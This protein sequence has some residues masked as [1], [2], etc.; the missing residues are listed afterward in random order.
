MMSS[1]QYSDIENVDAYIEA[2]QKG[3]F[4]IARLT[5][6]TPQETNAPSYHDAIR[7]CANKPRELSEQN[8]AYSLK[9]HT[10]KPLKSYVERI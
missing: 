5:K 3:E 4:P 1:I 2:V 10:L 6:L 7:S 9:R 8:S